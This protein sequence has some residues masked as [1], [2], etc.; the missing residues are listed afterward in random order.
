MA[1]LLLTLEQNVS[2][3]Q[4][5]AATHYLMEAQARGRTDDSAWMAVTVPKG[6]ALVL[7]RYQSPHSA[8]HLQA[9]ADRSLPVVRRLTG[10]TTAVLGNGSIHIALSFPLDQAPLPCEPRQILQ[11][12]GTLVARALAGIGLHGRYQGRDIVAVD[13]HPVGLVSFELDTNG[14]VLIE[15]I[16]GVTQTIQPDKEVIGYPTPSGKKFQTNSQAMAI[17]AL[18]SGANEESL[19]AAV[20]KA[21]RDSFSA[22]IEDRPLT[23]LEKERIKTLIPK[24]QV[25]TETNDRGH[26]YM[27]RWTSRPIDESIGFVEATVGVTQKRFL[28]AISVHGDFMAD[29]PGIELLEERLKMCP[30]ERRQIA[31]TI[32]EVL[33]AKNHVILGIRR[34]GSLLDALLD[35]AGKA[36]AKVKG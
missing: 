26:A 25:A 7:G 28:K 21:A 17:E 18:K 15:A 11:K 8:I 14:I 32:D 30:I 20:T 4:T 19:I 27:K 22:Q 23:A 5:I 13:D 29:S 3:E 34:L 16:L 35:A 6:Q 1:R 2:P 31:L 12:Y 36:V 10:G 24:V 9:C 33:G